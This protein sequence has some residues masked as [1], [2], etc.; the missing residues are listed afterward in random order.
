MTTVIR[1]A[2]GLLA[3]LLV[4]AALPG[5]SQ[6]DHVDPERARAD[7]LALP[8]IEEATAD[9]QAVQNAMAAA[10]SDAA[11]GLTWMTGDP[12]HS[13]NCPSPAAEVD[14]RDTTLEQSYAERAVHAQW[15]A[16]FSAARAIAGALLVGLSVIQYI[17]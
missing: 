3:A 13:S 2:A 7:F 5:C 9:L 16:V 15:P 10:V 14:G 8:P 1:T 17:E 11:G 6:G 12:R 4:V